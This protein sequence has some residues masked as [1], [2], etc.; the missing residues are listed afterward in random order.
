MDV[1]QHNDYAAHFEGIL[2]QN[3]KRNSISRNIKGEAI[4]P[5]GIWANI[6]HTLE[7]QKSPIP[8]VH[9]PKQYLERETIIQN[10]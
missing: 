1:Q 8:T 7:I 4:R 5:G 6:T 3:I 9:L 2:Q 10:W